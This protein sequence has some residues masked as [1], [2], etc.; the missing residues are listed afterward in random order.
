MIFLIDRE[1]VGSRKG[2]KMVTNAQDDVLKRLV[3]FTTPNIYP[4]EFF[5]DQNGTRSLQL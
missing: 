3:F 2:E 1:V 4:S 5:Y